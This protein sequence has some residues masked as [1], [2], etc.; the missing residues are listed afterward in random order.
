MTKSFE[1][2][3]VHK[4]AV[5]LTKQVF[6]LLN[7]SSLEKEFGFKDQIKRAVISITNNI[8]EGSE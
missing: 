2:F 7:N 8:A 3:E 4:K 5:L 1:E 6:K